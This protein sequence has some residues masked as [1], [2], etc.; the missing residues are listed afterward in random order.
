MGSERLL[1][2]NG[3]KAVKD[4]QELAGESREEGSP[5]RGSV[6]R[7]PLGSMEQLKGLV[8]LRVRGRQSRT[9]SGGTSPGPGRPFEE[10]GFYR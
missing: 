9:L 8:W 10:C 2:G 4:E 7:E 5:G 1:Q 3:V 6:Q